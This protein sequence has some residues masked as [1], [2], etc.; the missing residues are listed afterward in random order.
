MHHKQSHAAVRVRGGIFHN[1]IAS[2]HTLVRAIMARKKLPKRKTPAYQENYYDL[3]NSVSY[4]GKK[5][6]TDSL[7]RSRRASAEK[8]LKAQPAYTMHVQVPKKFKRLKTVAG[9]QQQL[10]GDLIDVSNLSAFNS[11]VNFILTV[12][13]PFS[14][15]AW[16]EPLLKKDASSVTAGFKKILER[17]D[18]KPFLFFSDQGKEFLNSTFTGL[19]K[20][21]NIRIYTSTDSSVKAAVVER[22]N[23]T[24]MTRVHKFLTR[25]NTHTYIHALQDIIENYNNTVHSTTGIAPSH[26]SHK[27]KEEIWLKLHRTT[28][29]KKHTT[30]HPLKLGDSVLIPKRKKA[31]SKGYLGGWTGEIFKIDNIRNTTPVTYDLVDLQGDKI[32]GVFYGPELQKV[33]P[34]QTFAIESVLDKQRG[35]LLVKWLYYPKKF[36]SW[37]PIKDLK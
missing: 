26:V 20:K 6:L 5:K 28:T 15:K 24:L 30:T 10:Q 29:R 34:P 32:I 31:F 2:R 13:D 11:K 17:L 1:T 25:E 33:T 23:K 18:F 27:N 8:W 36:N 16:A 4:T 22:F 12:I 21:N 3:K 35:K 37:I 9:F 14:K 19:L 7:P